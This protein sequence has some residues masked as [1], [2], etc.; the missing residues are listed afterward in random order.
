LTINFNIYLGE[1]GGGIKVFTAQA[2][3]SVLPT[4]I[5]VLMVC[6]DGFV[7]PAYEICDPGNIVFGYQLNT[8]TTT[9]QSFTDPHT[10]LPY[11]SGT[12]GCASDCSGYATSTCYTC[13]D[14]FKEGLEQCDTSDFGG[15][16]CSSFGYT[17]GDPLCTVD[18]RIDLGG[19]SVIGMD[20][21]RPGDTSHSGGGGGN[22][23]GST[24]FVPGTRM[25]PDKTLVVIKGKSY[26]NS[27]VRVLI[28]G[29]VT[30]IVKADSK[31]DFRFESGDLTPGLTTF[32]LWSE[33]SRGLKSTLLTL[34]FRVASKSITTVSNVYL[35]PTI[36]VDKNRV[37]KGSDVEIFGKSSPEVG[38]NVLVH[39]DEQKTATTS[40]TNTG[41]WRIK[42]NTKDLSEDFHTAMAI[43]RL[44]SPEGIIE[45]NYSRS[46]SFYVGNNI[47]EEAKCGKA[48]LNCDGSVNLVDFSI[49]LYNW[50]S[51]DKKS[52]INGDGKVGLPDFS[53]MMFYWTG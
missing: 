47:T 42:L 45:S 25:E 44:K 4:T 21:P 32:G 15:N 27:E 7:D 33:D 6:G 26:P 3:D 48:D 12:L 9:C 50:G 30:A 29:T 28:D 52:D 19:C 49:L 20:L 24:G 39:S 18:C 10:G 23:G 13:P 16:T 14:G 36:D 43:I 34:T 53:I 2:D 17:N 11:V 31:A 37:N 41:D 40:S 38:I 51:A 35:S 1:E 5:Q 8:G 46:V 22:P